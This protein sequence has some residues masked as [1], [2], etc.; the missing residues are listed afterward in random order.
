[1]KTVEQRLLLEMSKALSRLLRD[2][3][4]TQFPS[5]EDWTE[6]QKAAWRLDFLA[7]DLENGTDRAETRIQRMEQEW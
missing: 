5:D 7:E 6:H 3:D 1:M 2:F 4:R